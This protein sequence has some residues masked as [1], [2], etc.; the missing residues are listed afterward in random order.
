M[1]NAKE[2][3]EFDYGSIVG[4]HLCGKSVREIVDI[5]QKSKSIVSDVI[6]KWKS[7][8]TETAEK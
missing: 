7:R 5:L 4:F 1:S 3:C 6:V 2:L 8:G